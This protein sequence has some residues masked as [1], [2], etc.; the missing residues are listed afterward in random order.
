[1]DLCYDDD[2]DAYRAAVHQFA[3]EVLAPIAR[4]K[5]DFRRPL[6]REDMQAIA[7][8]MEHHDIATVPPTTADGQIDLIYLAIFIEEISRIDFGFASLA[9]AMFFQ[10]WDMASLLE[11]D[12]Q[13]H[14][15]GFMFGRGEM[16]AIALSEPD[17]ASNPSDMRTRAT[18]VENGWLLS[19][20]KLWTSHATVASGILIAARKDT[21][22]EDSGWI[23]LFMV[24]PD[25]EGLTISPIETIGMNA[26]SVCEIRI[27]DVFVP[28]A[29]DLTPGARGLSSA[30]HLVEQARIKMI[31]MAVGVA[32]AAL[33]LAVTYATQRTQFGRPIASFQLVQ[34]MLA[35]MS[36][37]TEASRLLGYRACSLMMRGGAARAE[38][39]RAKAYSTEA[40]VRACSLGIQVHGAMGLTKDVLAE[41]F[42]RDARMLT[43]PDGTT[44]IHK[45]VIGRHLTG[46]NAI[47]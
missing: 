23:S 40:A 10:V 36:T 29:A 30:L 18:R 2:Q 5:Y 21:R 7:A 39:S 24:E 31:F 38:V 16:T 14:R 19:G 6:S 4:E 42:F 11:T 1:M 9:N 45:L 33:D 41:K 26:T 43:I 25:T 44:E 17:A 20:Q 27:S 32:Q 8:D 12:E 13:R 15:Y 47:K 3:D 28:D 46:I 37:L 34:D 35:E 22:G